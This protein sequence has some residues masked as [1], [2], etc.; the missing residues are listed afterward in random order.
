VTI[1]RTLQL[2]KVSITWLEG[3]GFRLDGGA[4]FG[5]VPKVLWEKRYPADANNTIALVN[6]PLLVRTPDCNVLID[7]GLGNKL[8]EKQR[9][10]YRV[11]PSWAVPDQLARVGLAPDDIDFVILT[12][13]DFD[14][15]GGVVLADSSGTPRLTFPK[16]RHVLQRFE[17]EDI[18][19]PGLRAQS[20][21][22]KENF[23]LLR[24]ERNLVLNEDE[25][26][27]CPEIR[28]SHSGGH[29]RGHQVV[30]IHSEG[31]TALHLGDLL[32]THVH[33]NPLWV[34]AYDDFP[35]TVIDKK[36]QFLERCQAEKVWL[37]SYHDPAFRAFRIG[38]DRAIIERFPA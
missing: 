38:G 3:G 6:D 16:A 36:C 32:P 20:T 30:E 8:T 9:E 37:T 27:I 24:E 4:M 28:V 18:C 2:G 5:P 12:H 34:M 10:I 26:V 25:F 14:H 23:Q 1:Q 33:V 21:Y 15:A 17:W 13:G 29:T 19:N 11:E 7:S 22:I 31:Q 35:L